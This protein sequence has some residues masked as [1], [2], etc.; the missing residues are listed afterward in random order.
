MSAPGAARVR[1]P[2]PIGV[3]ALEADDVGLRRV[4]LDWDAVPDPAPVLDGTPG[5]AG[6]VLRRARR[7]LAEYFAGRRRAFDLPLRPAGTRF[8]KAVWRAMVQIPYG[9]TAS[10]GELAQD[11]GWPGAARAVGG[12]CRANEL[13]IVVPC[14]RVIAAD[15]TLGGYGL[16][17]PLKRRLLDLEAGRSTPPLHCAW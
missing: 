2:T 7:Q 15:G 5:S 17:L 8:Q 12:A 16:G 4:R 9:R 6:E 3:L 14:H 11:A 13:L 1:I 10:Y